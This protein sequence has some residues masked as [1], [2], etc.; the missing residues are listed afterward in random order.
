MSSEVE[1][2]TP[3]GSEARQKFGIGCAAYVLAAIIAVTGAVL[4]AFGQLPALL[5]LLIAAGLAYWGR[6][7]LKKAN[8]NVR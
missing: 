3:Q 5:L 1:P 7:D 2:A 4:L 8:P 6:R